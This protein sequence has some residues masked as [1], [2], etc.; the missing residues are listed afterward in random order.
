MKNNVIRFISRSLSVVVATTLIIADFSVNIH[1]YENVRDHVTIVSMGDSY[2]SGE[3]I[4]PFYGQ[5]KN[6]KLS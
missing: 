6:N 5:E 4:E 1:A 3:G 2:S